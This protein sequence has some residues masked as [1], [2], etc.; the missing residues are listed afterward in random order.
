[1]PKA[2][3]N[4]VKCVILVCSLGVVLPGCSQSGAR[5]T[6]PE[7]YAPQPSAGDRVRF[8]TGEDKGAAKAQKLPRNQ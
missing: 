6:E 5:V 8:G 4:V 1:M 3:I 2:L 7:E